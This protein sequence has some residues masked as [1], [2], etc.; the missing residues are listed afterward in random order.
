MHMIFSAMKGNNLI[1]LTGGTAATPSCGKVIG[2]NRF[3]MPSCSLCMGVTL[4]VSHT[5]EAMAK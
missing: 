1:I 2:A 5:L 4:V 3:H